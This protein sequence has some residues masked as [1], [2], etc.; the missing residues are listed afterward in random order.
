MALFLQLILYQYKF[1]IHFNICILR[2]L[3]Y[4]KRNYPWTKAKLWFWTFMTL[5][6]IQIFLSDD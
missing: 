1:K 2:E 3:L 5:Q 4:E 6:I